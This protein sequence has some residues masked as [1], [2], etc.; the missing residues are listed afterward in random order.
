MIDI[1]IEMGKKMSKRMNK[2]TSYTKLY[3]F[4]EA[5]IRDNDLGLG[6]RRAQSIARP[7]PELTVQLILPSVLARDSLSVDELDCQLMQLARRSG[8]SKTGV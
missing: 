6:T 5:R 3:V 1:L 8:V 2:I 7:L 4:L